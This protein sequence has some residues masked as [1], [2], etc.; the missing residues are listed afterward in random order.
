LGAG[1]RLERVTR[2]ATTLTVASLL[3]VVL[4]C[5]AFLMPV[6]YVTMEPGPTLDTLGESGGKPLIDFGPGVTTYDTTGSLALTTVRVTRPDGRVGVAQAFQAWFDDEVAIV[7]R[8]LIYP[9]EQSAAQAEQETQAQMSGSQLTSEVAGLTEAGYDVPSY[10]KVSTVVDDAPAHG[11]LEPGDRI[12]AVDGEPVSTPEE[13]VAAI[14]DRQPGDPVQ[15]EIRRDGSV[16]T[17]EITTVAD[18]EDERTPRV[19]IAV[20]PG[21]DFPVDVVYNVRRSIGGPSAGTMFALAIY[22]KLTPGSLTG[23]AFVAGTGEMYADG[24]VGPIGG[25]QQKI[26]AAYDEGATIFLVPSD[27]CDEALGA[28]V[29]RDDIQLLRVGSLHEAVTSLEALGDDPATAVPTC[30]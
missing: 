18:A 3:L 22:D 2:R 19:G 12:L 9:P 17:V 29:D 15:L 4:V 28:D 30:G 11:K 26:S 21:Y 23:G 14:S 25:V 27:N 20:A 16:Q 24:T 1:D 10:V 6:P 13:A 5:V 7:P 8:D